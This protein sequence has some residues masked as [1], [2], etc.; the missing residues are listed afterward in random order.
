[1]HIHQV[2]LTREEKASKEVR[3]CWQQEKNVVQAVIK[4]TGAV[5]KQDAVNE[6]LSNKFIK[7]SNCKNFGK[8]I[9]KFT[10]LEQSSHTLGM[11]TEYRNCPIEITH[12]VNKECRQ[13]LSIIVCY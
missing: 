1:M 5:F 8:K 11:A 12:T 4:A 2:Y 7:Y 9:R 10:I 3:T 13:K 6:L